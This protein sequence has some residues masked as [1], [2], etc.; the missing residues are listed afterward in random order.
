MA[1]KRERSKLQRISVFEGKQGLNVSN[2]LSLKP[3]F[4]VAEKCKSLDRS[5]K[6]RLSAGAAVDTVPASG[7]WVSCSSGLS[8][9]GDRANS[10]R[11]KSVVGMTQQQGRTN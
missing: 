6:T 5:T 10:P 1:L 3:E 4:G 11:S 7:I 8:N 2:E 9:D